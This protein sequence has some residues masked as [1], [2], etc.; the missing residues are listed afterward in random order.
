MVDI[1][2]GWGHSLRSYLLMFDLTDADLQQP[3]LDVAAGASS[4]NAE[5]THQ[6]YHAVSVDP[7]YQTS[8][9][10]IEPAVALILSQLEQ[11]V[12]DHIDKFVWTQLHDPEELFA[13]QKAMARIFM[14]DYAKGLAEGRYLN[15]ALPTLPFA[16][17]SF[18]M[19][20]CA[21]FIFDGPY[22]ELDFI[23]AAIKEMCRV[24]HETRIFPLLDENGDISVLLGPVMAAL[25]LD[26][27][28]VEIREVAYHAQKQGNAMLRVWAKTCELSAKSTG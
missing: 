10:M 27:Y 5:L 1:M 12:L 16:N 6:G 22:V 2:W 17:H 13:R 4:F 9:E 23:L 28:G 11:R 3:L 20:L 21:N 19:S 7:L 26:N 14:Q 24:A 15:A 8:P 25:Q 18:H